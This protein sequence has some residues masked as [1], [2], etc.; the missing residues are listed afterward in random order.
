MLSKMLPLPLVY[1]VVF[2]VFP[3]LYSRAN[4]ATTTLYAVSAPPASTPGPLE[5]QSPQ[6]FSFLATESNGRIRYQDMVVVTHFS[7]SE[8]SLISTPTTV[9]WTRYIY[10]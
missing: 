8:E 7:D 3:V 5:I 10:E 1:K 6:V 4:A 2:G 9:K